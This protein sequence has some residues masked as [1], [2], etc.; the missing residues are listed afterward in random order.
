MRGYIT[1]AGKIDFIR[2]HDCPYR[3]FHRENNGHKMCTL[4]CGKIGHFPDVL[5]PD[6]AAVTGVI[7]IIDEYDAAMFTLPQ[8]RAPQVYA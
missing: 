1:E 4:D 8:Q 5:L 6:Y 2:M 3:R 7:L